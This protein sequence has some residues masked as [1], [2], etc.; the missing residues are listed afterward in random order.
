MREDTIFIVNAGDNGYRDLDSGR[1]LAGSVVIGDLARY[2][3]DRQARLFLFGLLS[4][5][6]FDKTLTP[7]QKSEATGIFNDVRDKYASVYRF[8]GTKLEKTR[9]QAPASLDL[10]AYLSELSK[11]Y[12]DTN[13]YY[14]FVHEELERFDPPGFAFMEATWGG[15]SVPPNEHG[16]TLPPPGYT[17]GVEVSGDGKSAASRVV[18]VDSWYSKYLVARSPVPGNGGMPIVASRFVSDAALV[19]CKYIVETMLSKIPGALEYMLARNYRVGLVGAREN[20]TDLPENRAMPLW[21]PG[22]DWDA[23]GRGY[24]ATDWLPLMS[25]G[26][27]N[28][29]KMPAPYRERYPTESIMVHE[30]AHNIDAG[31]RGTIAGF[32][33]TLAA[34]FNHAMEHKLWHDTYSATNPE[35][36]WAEGVQAWFNTCRME[37]Y[38]AGQTSGTRFTLK[39]R[40]QL[41]NYDPTLH[42]LIAVYLPGVTLTGYHFDYE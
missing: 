29:V 26:E 15:R 19:Q 14:P 30:F 31:L 13:Y 23:R 37:V 9:V 32:E 7:G 16:I 10:P 17:K 38:P 34:A 24:G 20:V 5:L 25:C 12:V 18:P 35:E 39:T 22:T 8:N 1:D 40:E 11:A 4:R 42:D 28:I 3:T 6:Y 33:A 36:Y 27:E 21:W 41:K 2:G